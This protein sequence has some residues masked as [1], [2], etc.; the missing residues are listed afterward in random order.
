[1]REGKNGESN[2][3]RGRERKESP[4]TIEGGRERRVQQSLREGEEGESSNYKGRE[5]KESP[6]IIEGER[7]RRFQ[8][9]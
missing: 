5:K 2:N 7:G 8:Q 4:T 6:T 3:H 9:L 1:L